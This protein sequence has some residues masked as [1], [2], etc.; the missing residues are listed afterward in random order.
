[1]LEEDEENYSP[2]CPDCEACGEEG[3]CSALCCKHTETGHY[4]RGYLRDLKF[5]YAM[6]K[7]VYKLIPEDEKTQAEFD[8]IWNE[9]FEIFYKSNEHSDN[10]ARQQES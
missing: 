3:C 7:D 10:S 4:C 8:R 1:M 5:G 2:Y 9:N 6:Y